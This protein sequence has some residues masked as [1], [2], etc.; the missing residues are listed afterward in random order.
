MEEENDNE[1]C[2][3]G[4]QP[5]FSELEDLICE[6]I[7]E[8]RAMTLVVRRAYI[9]LFAIAIVPYLEKSLE[10]CTSQHWLDVF[11]QRYKLSLR[12]STTLLKWENTEVLK[13]ALAFK[14][15]IYGIDFSK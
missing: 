14:Y 10:K 8:K 7:V 15:F 12:R 5:L 6:W 11:L 4:R 1:A 13:R 3:S 9:Q 2:G